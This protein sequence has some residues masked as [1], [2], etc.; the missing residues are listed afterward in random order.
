MLRVAPQG[1]GP[2]QE[3]PPA[4]MPLHQP[5][6]G[7]RGP[8]RGAVGFP[9]ADEPLSSASGLAVPGGSIA[10]VACDQA[11][12]GTCGD[13]KSALMACSCPAALIW[14]TLSTSRHPCCHASVA[15]ANAMNPCCKRL[16]LCNSSR[17]QLA[18]ALMP[19]WKH[20]CNSHYGLGRPATRP[21]THQV[22]ALCSWPMNHSARF[23]CDAGAA[24]L[25]GRRLH[26]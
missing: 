9:D 18:S 25:P 12:G 20:A 23:F 3:R 10:L 26:S 2:S 14:F 8:H 21:A 22:W 19:H 15:A 5:R 24:R 6:Q 7:G 11:V 4:E 17:R 13:Q 1:V 16:H